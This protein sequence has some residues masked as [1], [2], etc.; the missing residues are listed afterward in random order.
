MFERIRE[1]IRGLLN[2]G[3]VLPYTNASPYQPAYAR[4]DQTTYMRSMGAVGTL[5]GIVDGLSED[6]GGVDWCLY[7]KSASG[8]EDDRIE[9]YNHRALDIWNNPNAHYTQ[10]ELVYAFNQHYDL[11]GEGWFHVVKNAIGLPEQLWVVR[12]DRI[13]PIPDPE[14]FLT[15][16]EYTAPDGKRIEIPSGDIMR[17]RRPNPLDPYR[18]MGAVQAV[19]YSLD[20]LRFGNEWNARFFQND[21]TPGVVIEVP[22]SL[23][24]HEYETFVSRWIAKHRGS[25]NANVPAFVEGGMKVVPNSYNMRDMQFQE[26]NILSR[27]QITEAFRYPKAMLGQVADSNRS[28]TEAMEYFYGKH[29][30]VPRLERIKK[31]LNKKFLPMFGTYSGS[32]LEFDYKSPVPDDQAAE[33]ENKKRQ[34]E[35]FKVLVDAGVD[36]EEAATVVGLPKMKITVKEEPKKQ[37]PQLVGESGPELVDFKRLRGQR[38]T[39]YDREDREQEAWQRELDRLMDNWSGIADAQRSQLR[40]QIATIIDNNQTERLAELQVDKDDATGLLTQALVKMGAVGAN[41]I[42]ALAAQSGVEMQPVAPPTEEMSTLA[43]TT[44]GLLAV[45]L[46]ASAGR[47]ALRLMNPTATGAQ[48]AEAVLSY[49]GGLSDV[50]LK[51]QLGGTLWAAEGAGR[52]HTLAAGPEASYYQ[53]SEIRDR[54]ACEPCRDVD[55]KKFY[56]LES[57]RRAYP[58]GGYHACNGGVR[59]RGTYEPVWE[60]RR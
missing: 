29:M 59:C 5:F 6:V 56:T 45:G 22:G 32:M 26:L 49:L 18:G 1:Y 28:N 24:D 53:A 57:A 3:A 55:G 38:F 52:Y 36:P 42:V 21:A 25:R 17:T 23:Q 44:T 12:P 15:A 58:M 51:D 20:A 4:P 54:N 27:E 16:Y 8:V 14:N 30:L 2:R 7:Q 11:V 33:T 50:F 35:S 60:A 47:E 31:I 13:A 40:D 41:D 10:D 19:M 46:A 43:A 39:V 9:V 37:P 34:A 48:V